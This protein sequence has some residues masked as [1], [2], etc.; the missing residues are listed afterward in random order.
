MR[1]TL[2]RQTLFADF[3]LQAHQLVEQGEPVTGERLSALYLKILREYYGHAQG[4]CRIDDLM[5]IE[6]AYIPHFYSNYY[7]YQYATSL[8]ASTSIARA[9]REEAKA[10]KVKARDA[11]LTLLSSG[12][13]KLPIELLKDAGVDMTTSKPFDAAIA[14]MNAIMDD[15][16][17]ILARRPKAAK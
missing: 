5:A 12:S 13:S 9:I 6:W 3:E 11:Y 7:V 16:E 8:V 10:G 4:V 17:K 1:T 14:E 2:F 15:M